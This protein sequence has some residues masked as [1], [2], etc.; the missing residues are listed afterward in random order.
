MNLRTSVSLA[1][2]IAFA[3]A[4]VSAASALAQSPSEKHPVPGTAAQATAE[5]AIKDLFANEYSKTTTT[6]RRRL[7]AQLF[8]SALKTND[9]LA[10]RFVLFREACDIAA[11]AGDPKTALAAADALA[12]E[13]D[14]N[15]LELKC[16]TLE[17]AGKA[18]NLSSANVTVVTR[19]TLNALEQ[20][21]VAADNFTAAADLV[22]IARATSEKSPNGKL[23]TF[24]E[25]LSHEID[26]LKKEY[27]GVAAAK[28]KLET[29]P[30][31]PA[32]NLAYGQY[33]CLAKGD[34]VTGLPYLSKGDDADL[35]KLAAAE[36][37]KPK[38]VVEWKALADGWWDLSNR[39]F[40]SSSTMP[41]RNLQERSVIW[42]RRAFGGLPPLDQRMAD[43]RIIEGQQRLTALTAI[44][45]FPPTCEFK[46]HVWLAGTAAVKT[47][48]ADEGFCFLTGVAGKFE[49]GGEDVG[50]SI[51]EDGFWYLDGNSRQ[52]MSGRAV[53]YQTAYR[54]LFAK[55][56]K[57][58]QW[59]PKSE[60]IKMISIHE[61]FCFLSNVGG[62]FADAGD[63]ISVSVE[64]DGYWYLSG[65][66]VQFV[67]GRALCVRLADPGAAQVKL[68]H[69]RWTAQM[70]PVRMC[71]KD[72][73]ICFLASV[74][75]ALR[76]GGEDARIYLGKDGY[77][78]LGA[79][80]RQNS[81]S[82]RAFSLTPIRTLPE[83]DR[84]PEE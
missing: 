20:E 16:K 26:E 30:D 67:V 47:I 57:E 60:P 41:R 66:A 17:V 76:G 12:K 55:E 83:K 58:Y 1:D 28:K 39:Y 53:S 5:K 23:T 29:Q 6:L 33:L 37:A 54:R 71:H 48:R 73:G 9:D 82:L 79:Q 14:I 22:R 69:F 42:Y 72:E 59:G 21:A 34:W 10:V 31:D 32:A 84:L 2:L 65:R 80:S 3:A 64:K 63:E 81:L 70:N 24:L 74:S 62:K 4:F 56:I 61:G 49:G 46:E 27:A 45:Q 52:N 68:T 51:R 77:W 11:Q 43:K 75:G 19:A 15:A 8:D 78:Y 7:A 36:L 25:S 38:A 13:F 40:K 44:R 18:P 35:K 50:V